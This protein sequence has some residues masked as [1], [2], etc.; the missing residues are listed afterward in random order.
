MPSKSNKQAAFM[1]AVANNPKFSKKVG[2]SQNVGREFE[3][4]DERKAG[5][6]KRYMKKKMKSKMM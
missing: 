5:R 4:V 6:K 3:A 1:R 2:V